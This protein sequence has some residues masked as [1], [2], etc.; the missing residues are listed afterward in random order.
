M[1]EKQAA[2]YKKLMYIR[3]SLS[4]GKLFVL[5]VTYI[6]LSVNVLGHESGVP[7]TRVRTINW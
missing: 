4:G 1:L 2:V 7:P 3:V 6:M 5:P